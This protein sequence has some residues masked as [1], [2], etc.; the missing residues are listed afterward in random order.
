M[1]GASQI[2]LHC[3]PPRLDIGLVEGS[4]GTNPRGIVD[5]DMQSAVLTL[6]ASNGCLDLVTT[7][8]IDAQ[9]LGLTPRFRDELRRLLQVGHGAGKPHDRHAGAS[10]CQRDRP[11]DAATRPGDDRDPLTKTLCRPHFRIWQPAPRRSARR[12]R[13]SRSLRCRTLVELDRTSAPN[14]RRL[15]PDAANSA[16]DLH[17][18]RLIVVAVPRQVDLPRRA[19]VRVLGMT[20]RRYCEALERQCRSC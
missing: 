4:D 13:L 9:R 3:R 12:A 7:R 18:H 14:L 17:R 10:E 1:N 15:P 2:D 19:F 20:L 16:S 6:D 8:D 11:T 5:E